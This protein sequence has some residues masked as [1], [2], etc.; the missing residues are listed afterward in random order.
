[1]VVAETSSSSLSFLLCEPAGLR[2]RH[3]RIV[4]VLLCLKKSLLPSRD[5]LLRMPMREGRLCWVVCMRTVVSV[6]HVEFTFA[7]T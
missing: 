3:T 5:D 7:N 6:Y 1:M 2:V 4:A